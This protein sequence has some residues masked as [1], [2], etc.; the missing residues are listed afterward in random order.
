MSQPI[1]F[2]KLPYPDIDDDADSVAAQRGISNVTGQNLSLVNPYFT[3]HKT[4][5]VSARAALVTGLYNLKPADY[6]WRAFTS[7]QF[8][9]CSLTLP[10][11][12]AF[13]MATIAAEVAGNATG[14]E[15]QV[16]YLLEGPGKPDGNTRSRTA[17]ISRAVLC[18]GAR[19]TVFIP[20]NAAD[21]TIVGGQLVTMTPHWRVGGTGATS[22]TE[23]SIQLTAFSGD[24]L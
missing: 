1:V 3:S 7:S 16:S 17:M 20:G 21:G 4:R 8:P 14:T 12:V 2:A 11:N 22:L 24:P 6:T 18:Y 9:S 5:M 10:K 19:T 23:A 13:I 15:F